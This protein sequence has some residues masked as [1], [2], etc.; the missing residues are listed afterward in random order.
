MNTTLDIAEH[1]GIDEKVIKA[2]LI[3]NEIPLLNDSRISDKYIQSVLAFIEKTDDRIDKKVEKAQKTFKYNSNK[4][5]VSIFQDDAISF[6]EKLPSDS[7]D[8]IVTDQAY[9][10]LINKYN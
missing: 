2:Y 8:L 3:D 6:L 1:Y 10:T 7:V 9:S 4:N 5:I